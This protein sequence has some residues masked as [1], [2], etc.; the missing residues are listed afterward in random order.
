MKTTIIV[1]LMVLSAFLSQANTRKS[2]SEGWKVG[3]AK[4]DITPKNPMWLA[5]Y[6][7]RTKVSEG[8]MHPLWA[9]CLFF[10]DAKG[11]SSA[12]LT[13]DVVGIS[14]EFGID[15]R[16]E[17]SRKTSIPLSNILINCSH[18]HSGP[19]LDQVLTSIYPLKESD[20]K[21]IVKYSKWLKET[22]IELSLRA[23]KDL[24][25]VNLYAK[26]GVSRIQVNRRTNQE[27]DIDVLKELNG[28]N[29][30]AV[31]TIKVETN[32]GNLKAV[33]FGYA[34]HPTVLSGYQWS[35]DYAGFAQLELEKLYPGTAALFFQGAGGD[36]N[37]LPRR[38]IPLAKQYGKSLAAAVERVLNEEMTPLA[39]SFKSSAATI[40][41]G[42]SAAPSLSELK[43]IQKEAGQGYIY[44]WSSNLIGQYEAG[45]PLLRNY[46]NYPIQVWDFG[47]QK[48]IS[49]GGEITIGYAVKLKEKYGDQI[50]VMGYTND[51]MGY[52]PT[53]LILEE[54]GYEGDTSQRA[55]GLPSKWAAGI[56]SQI[57]SKINDLMDAIN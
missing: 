56:E 19:V 44:E 55:Y 42:L 40:E 29:D 43:Q 7:S 28:P 46:P 33:V 26:N 36:Q 18:T 11:N 25:P 6:A 48:I 41:L 13:L 53:E 4:A 5:G 10:Q 50:F 57:L 52:I 1:S 17:I 34:C 3:V 21:E 15:V 27:K 45:K 8:A 32:K 31:P 39:G 9:K 38:T 16:T 22:L 23:H 49:L 12:L 47:G 51:V 54:G 24:E 2:I 30:F 37:P 14:S 35:G 20:K